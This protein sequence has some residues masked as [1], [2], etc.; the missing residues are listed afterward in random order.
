[1]CFERLDGT[2]CLILPV[3]T[4][5]GEFIFHAVV[6]NFVFERF[7]CLVVQ[8]VF[9]QAQACCS[10]SVYDSLV[11]FHHFPFCPVFHR[12]VE[13]VVGIEVNC[14]HDVSVSTLGR[15]R[16]ATRLVGVYCFAQVLDVKK[17]SW[18]RIMSLGGESS[19]SC[20]MW[21][22]ALLTSFSNAFCLVERMPCRC[23]LRWPFAVSIESGKR[24][25]TVLA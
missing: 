12:L 23:P 13:N 18:C 22:I 5:G 19:C 16:K 1:M 15:V 4:G 14:H 25:C 20:L 21:T 9:F 11:R 24:R 2:F 3:V 8:Y 17:K 10:H 6:S 7:R